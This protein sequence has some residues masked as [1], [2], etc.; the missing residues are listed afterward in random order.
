ME[1]AEKEPSYTGGKLTPPWFNSGGRAS[2]ESKNKF[3]EPSKNDTYLRQLWRGNSEIAQF[4]FYTNA[5][6][7]NY[8]GI[9]PWSHYSCVL[10][11]EAV[12]S[13]N[14]PSQQWR[15]L[16]FTNDR[17]WGIDLGNL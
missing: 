13:D 9:I 12:F 15:D 16:N 17:V 11:G 7:T 10:S 14:L 4:S 1:D 2:I 3:K 8:L 5:I 6:K